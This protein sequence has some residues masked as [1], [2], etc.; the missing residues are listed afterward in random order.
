MVDRLRTERPDAVL[1]ACTGPVVTTVAADRLFRARTRPVLITG[2]PGISIP[3]TDRAV[4]AR[5]GCDLFLLHSRR[6]IAAFTG[7]AAR[8]RPEL[9]LGL[10]S[11]PFLSRR[12]TADDQQ[13]GDQLIFAAQAKVPS[14]RSDREQILLALADAGRAVIKLR[15][16]AEEQQTH[17]EQ[18]P[19]PVLLADL[20]TQGIIARST[21]GLL[22]GSMAEALR[23]ARAL[24]TVSSTAALESM[25][26]GLPTLIISD[27]GV[28]DAM[29]N[30][31]FDGS[32]CLGTLDDLRRGRIRGPDSSWLEANYFHA[33][34]DNDWLDH[35]D[36]L[37]AR[38]AAG[39]LPVADLPASCRHAC[40]AAPGCCCRLGSGRHFAPCGASCAR[41]SKIN[42]QSSRTAP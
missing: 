5:T 39:G 25:A 10:A 38:R 2:L 29:I 6:E 35:L 42:S 34:T 32:G 24:V 11:L 26:V 31:V 17:H 18:W 12:P 16:A 9:T 33:D 21:V 19:Y 13:R 40:T 37:L 1:L 8:H 23:S 22:G 7:L 30:T 28:S 3:A 15:A 36:D 4:R 20:E 27:F 41:C 14:R